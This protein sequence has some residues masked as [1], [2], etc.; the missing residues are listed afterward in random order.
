MLTISFTFYLAWLISSSTLVKPT[1]SLVDS[2]Y[3]NYEQLS[4]LL[5]DYSVK[6]PNKTH[7]YSIG[8]TVRDRDIWV[9]SIAAKQPDVH[10]LLRPEV[11]LIG[12][13]HGNELPSG[14]IL[15]RFI[16]HLLVNPM[17]DPSVDYIL[18]NIRVHILV[19]LNPD[20]TELALASPLSCDSKIGKD[21]ANHYDLNMNFPDKFVCN[22]KPIQPE[23]K[24]IIDW[25]E[26][27]TFVLSAK[28]QTGFIVA[29]FPWENFRLTDN[30]PT[31]KRL[32]DVESPTDY[33][34]MFTYLASRYSFNHLTMTNET[35]DQ[36]TFQDGITNG[37]SI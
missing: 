29:S 14:E 1:Q 15:L 21:N 37:G 17:G 33:E 2:T 35:C 10:L 24:A 25:L 27:N 31:P 30:E 13:I 28:F 8:K 3:H 34:D 4:T 36:A 9:I 6:Y 11:K 18:K 16:D 23:T 26:T 5:K 22:R 7:L 32:S 12:N 20:G 19:S